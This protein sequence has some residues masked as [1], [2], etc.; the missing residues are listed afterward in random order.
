MKAIRWVYP[1]EGKTYLQFN[2]GDKWEHY[3]KSAFYQADY[4]IEGS[5]KGYRTMQKL[6]EAG[7]TYYVP[8]YEQT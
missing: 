5:S 2:N 8:Q 4:K 1:A 6:L 7:Y 3:T